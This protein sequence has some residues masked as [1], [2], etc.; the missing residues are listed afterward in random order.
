MLQK[1]GFSFIEIISQCPVS[2]GRRVGMRDGL[3]FWEYF[4]ENSI[5][6]KYARNKTEEEL[7]G[8]IIVGKLVERTRVEFSESLRRIN[9]LVPDTNFNSETNAGH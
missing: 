8:K 3:A 4:K 6:V 5:P 2:Y 1:D 9:K 7:D